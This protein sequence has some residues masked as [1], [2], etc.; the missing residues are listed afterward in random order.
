MPGW[1]ASILGG[2]YVITDSR[3]ICEVYGQGSP[4]ETVRV[5][6]LLAAAEDMAEALRQAQAIIG[7]LGSMAEVAA[8]SERIESVLARLEPA[9]APTPSE[10][11]K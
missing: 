11:E 5:T 2:Y 1:R 7:A 3:T 9:V 4:E 8:L 6:R 10:G